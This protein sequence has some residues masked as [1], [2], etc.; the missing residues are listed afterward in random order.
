MSLINKVA[1]YSVTR[2]R[3]VL[4]LTSNH[5]ESVQRKRCRICMLIH[6]YVHAS[7]FTG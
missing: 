4:E 6:Y 7:I 5:L 3:G 2:L 1:D